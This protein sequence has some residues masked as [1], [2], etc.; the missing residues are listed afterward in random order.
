MKKI[1]ILL[2]ILISFATSYAQKAELVQRIK[3]DHGHMEGATIDHMVTLN[4]SETM[5]AKV[6]DD[7][8]YPV[9]K[10][11][12]SRL[13][14]AMIQCHDYLFDTKMYGKCD[15]MSFP[16]EETKTDCEKEII[17]DKDKINVTINGASIE[18]KE[19]SYRLMNSYISCIDEFLGTSASAFG[20]NRNW[21]PKTK[22]LH[23]VLDLS[24]TAK[25]IVVKWSADFKTA[26]ITAPVGVEPGDW[27]DKIG[28]GL[29]RGGS[30]IK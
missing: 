11:R 1:S 3:E 15:N 24:A 20:F 12:F 6:L 21:R 30:K 17:A 28:K 4:L 16:S 26:T 22:E 13:S 27:V 9:G 29:E 7:N 19:L 10:E 8:E 14:K 18:G 25:D 2:A 5:W 23:I